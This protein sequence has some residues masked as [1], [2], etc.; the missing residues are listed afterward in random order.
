MPRGVNTLTC[1]PSYKAFFWSWWTLCDVMCFFGWSSSNFGRRS[2]K[3]VVV[4]VLLLLL[5]FFLCSHDPSKQTKSQKAIRWF[6]GANSQLVSRSVP[7]K[8]LTWNLKNEGL[9]KGISS[10]TGMSILTIVI[11]WIYLIP[12]GWIRSN[13]KRVVFTPIYW[14]SLLITSMG[15]SH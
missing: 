11:K 5:L 6:S 3:G 8:K 7:Q 13:K 12:L 10:S 15:P 9:L 1:G 2:C 14:R 4:V